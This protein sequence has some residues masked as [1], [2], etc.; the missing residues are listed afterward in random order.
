LYQKRAAN[1]MQKQIY[2]FLITCI[3]LQDIKYSV[4]EVVLH[5]QPNQEDMNWKVLTFQIDWLTLARKT[6]GI[7]FL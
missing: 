3:R 2:L 5:A 7:D 6:D 1:K 4:T